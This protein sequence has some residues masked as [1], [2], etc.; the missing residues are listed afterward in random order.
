MVWDLPQVEYIAGRAHPKV[1]PKRTHGIA[2]LAAAAVL[3]RCGKGTGST[4]TELRCHLTSGTTLVPDV[5]YLSYDR[6]R[7]LSEPEREEP[8]FAPDVVVEIRSP[9]DPDAVVHE[10][11][12]LY[13]RFGSLAVLNVDPWNR[14][15]TVDGAG[16]TRSTFR[17]GDRVVV[18][19]VAWL[20][21]DAAELFEDLNEP[22]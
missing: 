12:A 3:K 4:A 18:P 16:G 15:V 14:S 17:T 1:S 7:P 13:L 8:P 2:Q 21:F 11:T 19:E 22:I 20:S 10:K 9:S 6:L 5:A